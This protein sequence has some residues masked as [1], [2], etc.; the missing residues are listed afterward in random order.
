MKRFYFALLAG[1]LCATPI[2]HAQIYK[3]IDKDGKVQYTDQPPLPGAS[4][5]DA[6]KV[7]NTRPADS[8]APADKPLKEKV[9]DS[10]KKKTEEAEKQKKDEETAKRAAQEKERCNEATIYLRSLQSGERIARNDANGERFFLEGEKRDAEVA[11]AQQ[12]VSES[13]K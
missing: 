3:W 7:I 12:V 11:R 4:K 8:T 5:A 1:A 10:D 13:C 6:Q 2:T 9:K